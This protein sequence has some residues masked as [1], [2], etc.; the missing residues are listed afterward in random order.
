M[1]KGAF[2]TVMNARSGWGIH[3]STDSPAQRYNR[4]FWDAFLEEN[5]TNLG[6]MN[7]DSKE[8]V[9]FRGTMLVSNGMT[10]ASLTLSSC[11]PSIIT[12]TK[13]RA[14]IISLSGTGCGGT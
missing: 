9:R 5:I 3:G 2:A 6:R 14:A 12:F 13:T 8:P 11:F 7:Q 1:D 10:L 4:Q